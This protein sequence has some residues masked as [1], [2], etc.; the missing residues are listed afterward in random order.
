[1]RFVMVRLTAIDMIMQRP[2]VEWLVGV[3]SS[4]AS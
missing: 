1:M 4:E 2:V 3:D